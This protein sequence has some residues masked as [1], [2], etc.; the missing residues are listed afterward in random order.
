MCSVAF[1][2]TDFIITITLSAADATEHIIHNPFMPASVDHPVGVTLVLLAGL[3]GIFLK[4]FREAIGLA[5]GIVIVYLGLNAIVILVGIR[6]VLVHPE[7]LPRWTNALAAQHTNPMMMLAAALLV[8]PKLA[9]GLSGFETGVA[10]MPLVEGNPGDPPDMPAGR[11]HNTQRLLRTA[12]FIMSVLLISSSTVTTLLIP[13][14][15]F[16]GSGEAAGRALSYLAHRHLGDLF[17]T[18]YDISTIAILWFAGAS[19]NHRIAMVL[20]S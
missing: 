12:A 6:E 7:Y 18:V 14:E 2:A 20:M 3:G 1:A 19:A 5:V 8:F 13:P 10:V 17:G 16:A 4:G 15:A 9:L 11:I